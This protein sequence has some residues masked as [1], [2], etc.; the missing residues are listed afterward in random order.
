M[1]GI[2]KRE[3][4]KTYGGNSEHVS[5]YLAGVSSATH[6]SVHEAVVAHEDGITVQTDGL[7]IQIC[8]GQDFGS[9]EIRVG[10]T[11]K[12][13]D[14]PMSLGEAAA[15]TA[16]YLLTYSNEVSPDRNTA[17]YISTNWAYLADQGEQSLP[18]STGTYLV[19]DSSITVGIPNLE[20]DIT[21]EADQDGSGQ[22]V[23]SLYY[24]NQSA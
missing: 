17:S 5:L 12:T 6:T 10:E 11:A 19:T 1:L 9:A 24:L 16:A 14:L 4:Q 2:L 13:L 23:Q 15:V 21:V 7:P 3:K 18:N 8:S 22:L 20:I